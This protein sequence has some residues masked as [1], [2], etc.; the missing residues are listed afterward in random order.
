MEISSIPPGAEIVLDGRALTDR[1][2]THLTGLAG[3]RTLHLEVLAPGYLPWSNEIPLKT[4]QHL[5]VEAKLELPPPPAPEPEPVR[6]P[7]PVPSPL[8]PVPDAVAWP[9]ATFELDAARH[10]L[11]LAT[12]NATV[13][14]FEPGKTYRVTLQGKSS[15]ASW[16]YYVMSE[17]GALPGVFGEDPLQIKSASQFYAFH[18]PH[19]VLDRPGKD[20]K[21]RG[22]QVAVEGAKT[23][24]TARVPP[25]LVFP[26]SQR[27][28]VT[29]LNPARAYEL[30][31]HQ[32]VPPAVTN[33]RRR[34]PV[35]RVLVGS[36]QGLTIAVVDEVTRLEDSPSFWVTVIDERADTESGRL[37]FELKEV[38]VTPK[39]RRR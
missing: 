12:S 38:R 1:T 3:N 13:V 17:G 25:T 4:G 27:V 35:S 14:D 31:P 7:E 2:P 20:D 21:A 8:P 33:E 34:A 37:W 9:T 28:T 32:R 19:S 36:P 29:G 16:G 5:V 23:A 24:K 30:T 6:T 11:E 18:V 39:K 26:S 22:L 10:R 15:S